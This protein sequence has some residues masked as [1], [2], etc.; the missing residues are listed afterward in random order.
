MIAERIIW[1]LEAAPIQ[2]QMKRRDRD[3][4]P[5]E[6]EVLDKKPDDDE[7]VDDV[8]RALDDLSTCRQFIQGFGLG[9]I[10]ILAIWSYW[11]RRGLDPVA[12]QILT[13][14]TLEGD[15]VYLAE[16]AKSKS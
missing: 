12:V 11:E 3:A 9:P 16:K 8:L 2:E 15:R 4:Y 1:Q 5:P 14:A 6:R 10:P 13:H 7:T